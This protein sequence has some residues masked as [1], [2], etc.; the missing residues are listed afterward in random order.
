MYDKDNEYT[1]GRYFNK[2]L[3]TYL[4]RAP[5]VLYSANVFAFVSRYDTFT[6]NFSATA[7]RC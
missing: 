7:E 6:K 5:A 3:I 2:V 4:S 1:C